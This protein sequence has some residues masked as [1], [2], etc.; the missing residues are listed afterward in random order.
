M[1]ITSQLKDGVVCDPLLGFGNF[2]LS[3]TFD[4]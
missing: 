2:V 1:A 4:P 3:F